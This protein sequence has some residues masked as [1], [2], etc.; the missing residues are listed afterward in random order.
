DF[1]GYSLDMQVSTSMKVQTRY[2]TSHNVVALISGSERPEEYII[3]SAHWDHLGIGKPDAEGD[4][5]Y[6]G[7]FDNASGTAG[8]LVVAN[9][10][11]NLKN[12]PHRSVVFLAVTA[13]E[14]GLWGSAFYAANPIYPLTKTVA[15]INMDGINPYGP[16]K[17][18]VVVGKGQSD[19]EEY[20]E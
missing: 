10:F 19:L 12:P 15:N 11:Q 18:I 6:N 17:D 7:A 5:I 4:S 8:L 16:M 1:T 2:D 20:L 3:Y 14:Q 9:A 13:E